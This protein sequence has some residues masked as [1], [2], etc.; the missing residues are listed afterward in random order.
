LLTNRATRLPAPHDDVWLC[1]LDDPTLGRPRAEQAFEGTG[2]TRIVL[3]HSP[4]GLLEIGEREFDLAFCGH[5]HAGQIALPGG[6]ALV[7]P[8]GRLSRTYLHGTYRV[9]T[10]G[11]ML[12]SAGVGASTLP[13][14]LFTSPEVHLCTVVRRAAHGAERAREI[15]SV[16][17]SA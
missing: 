8:K 11:R 5:T 15:R 6:H 9:G 10:R 14:R 13:L 12:V 2:E 16:A 3:M 17:R 7:V 1:G 4:D